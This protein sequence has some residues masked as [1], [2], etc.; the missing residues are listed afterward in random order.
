[1]LLWALGIAIILLLIP[2]TIHPTS[3]SMSTPNTTSSEE[4][5]TK[6]PLLALEAAPV[7]DPNAP[8][9]LN[10]A[11]SEPVSLYDQLGPAIVAK[12]GVR[13]ALQTAAM[14]SAN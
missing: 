9:Q 6:A 11:T 2:T 4:I 7:R 12:D 3:D 10:V 13:I 5:T 1:M 14:V 8:I